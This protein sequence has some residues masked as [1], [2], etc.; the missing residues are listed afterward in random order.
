MRRRLAPLLALATV[1]VVLAGCSERSSSTHHG[2]RGTID[3]TASGAVVIHNSSSGVWAESPRRLSVSTRIGAAQG[4]GPEV[5]GRLTAV[6][7]GPHALLYAL[8][9]Q[10]QEIRVF[11]QPGRY[12]R[13]IGRQGSGPGEL[14]GAIGFSWGPEGHL[15]V[16]D[17]GNGRYSVFDSTGAFLESRPRHLGVVLPW[18]GGF[19]EAG[20]L[21]DV[22]PGVSDRQWPRFTYYR[23]A[24]PYD[25]LEGL[26]PLVFR[27]PV[28]PAPMAAF[29]LIPRLTFAFDPT[30]N[31]WFAATSSYRIYE[32][33]PAGDTVRVVEMSRPQNPVSDAQKDSIMAEVRREHF[34]EGMFS[35]ADLPDTRPFLKRIVVGHHGR[36]W[37]MAATSKGRTSFDVF[38]RTGRYLGSV[39]SP[40]SISALTPPVVEGD[41]LL[42]VTSDSLGVQ[43]LI[44]AVVQSVGGA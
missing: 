34:P 14:K 19:D 1:A 37:V 15:W 44:L 20:D 27:H 38:G 7:I 6:G 24:P 25:S 23:L 4:T 40:L 35:R 8:D 29:D 39:E 36:V 9:G 32:R 31:F 22:S 42:G 12:I 17:A 11:S 28:R 18:L 43:S 26:P 3:T 21:Y 30:G 2:W 5:F 33:T 41:T 16:V 13:T 10:A